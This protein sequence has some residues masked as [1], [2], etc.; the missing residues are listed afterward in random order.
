[1]AEA[2][3]ING[4]LQGRTAGNAPPGVPSATG[5]MG[6]L[7]R[8]G[9]APGSGWDKFNKFYTILACGTFMALGV[10]GMLAFLLGFA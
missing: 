6:G 10:G 2:L 5:V 7:A 4:L 8:P 9:P 1:M 3:G